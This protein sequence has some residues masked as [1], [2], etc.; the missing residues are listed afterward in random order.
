MILQ[1]NILCYTFRALEFWHVVG[2]FMQGRPAGKEKFS[3]R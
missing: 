3:A 1:S 2:T